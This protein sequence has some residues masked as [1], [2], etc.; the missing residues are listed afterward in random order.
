MR[1]GDTIKLLMRSILIIAL[2]LFGIS[3]YSQSDFDKRL[4]AKFSDD[5]IHKL[6]EV[7]P[8]SVAYFEFFLDHGYKLIDA[9]DGKDF[10]FEGILKVKDLDN[11]NLFELGLEHPLKEY[12][13]YQLR[14]SDKI[15]VLVPRKQIIKHFNKKQS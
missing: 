7:Q 2:C 1:Q 8:N 5:Q 15:L 12:K 10:Q 4:L 14:N 3:A 6:Q 13:F 11:I 9:K